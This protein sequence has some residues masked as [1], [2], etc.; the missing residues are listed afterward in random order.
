MRD[1][2]TERFSLRRW[3]ERLNDGGWQP[4]G[5]LAAAVFEL[6]RVPP[7]GAHWPEMVKRIWSELVEP[8]QDLYRLVITAGSTL[9][10]VEDD[11]SVWFERLILRQ[12]SDVREIA[13]KLL[14]YT[15]PNKHGFSSAREF[16][17]PSRKMIRWE[18]CTKDVD[19]FR[20]TPAGAVLL[21]ALFGGMRGGLRCC[22]SCGR[23]NVFDRSAP[24][25][26]YCADCKSLSSPQSGRA[27]GLPLWKIDR[28][29]RVAGRMRRRGF[30]RLGLVAPEQRRTWRINALARLRQIKERAELDSW[31]AE[32][33][34]RG[35]PGRP[36]TRK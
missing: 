16:L 3:Q 17:G 25:R 23:F 28:W 11:G 20:V 36:K 8:E 34:P 31:E 13:E 15:V 33:A 1:V 24:N 10:G 5:A 7:R 6:P 21:S 14:E 19:H 12:L 27:R 9:A 29:N 22:A 2:F 26:R 18:W 32:I 35:Q 30:K 4:V